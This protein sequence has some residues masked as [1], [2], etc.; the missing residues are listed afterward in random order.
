VS[1]EVLTIF[2][3]VLNSAALARAK[4]STPMLSVNSKKPA[5]GPSFTFT[6]D[7]SLWLT[8]HP[9]KEEHEPD[10]FTMEILRSKTM[11]G[12]ELALFP[13]QHK[14]ILSS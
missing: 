1:C 6:T 3:K 8:K 13:A 12:G 2:L 4:D 5:L 11:V 10:F 9:G 14:L 7:T